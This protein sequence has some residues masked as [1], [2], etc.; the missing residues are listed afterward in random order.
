MIANAVSNA[1]VNGTAAACA[2]NEAEA[3]NGCGSGS[4]HCCSSTSTTTTSPATTTVVVDIE[5]L[6][7][8][9]NMEQNKKDSKDTDITTETEQLDEA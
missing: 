1:V 7:N 6:L 2:K 4:G 5:D 9:R 3:V 8:K